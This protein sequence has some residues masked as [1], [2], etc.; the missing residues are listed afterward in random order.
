LVGY[1]AGTDSEE[2]VSEINSEVFAADE[3]GPDESTHE[4]MMINKVMGIIEEELSENQKK[5][6][7]LLMLQGMPATVLAEQMGVTRNALYK[8]AHDARLNLKK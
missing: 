5:A 6:I 1:L 3:P 8:L 2:D 4:K 7:M